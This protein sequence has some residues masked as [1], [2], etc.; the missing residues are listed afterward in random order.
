MYTIILCGLSLLYGIYGKTVGCLVIMDG[1]ESAG[2][3]TERTF[4]RKVI[5]KNLPLDAALSEIMSKPLTTIDPESPRR[6]AARLMVKNKV[7]RL[8]VVNEAKLVGMI[9]A[10]DFACQL[11]KKTIT[12]Q[13]VDAMAHY[14][15]RIMD[16]TMGVV[17]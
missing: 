11:S 17:G 3:V 12:E 15:V 16:E 7:R 5:A 9:I 6:E 10:S 2:I 13:I 1:E 14:P 4:V 8:L